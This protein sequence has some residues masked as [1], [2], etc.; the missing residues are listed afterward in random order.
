MSIIKRSFPPPTAHNVIPHQPLP[1]EHHRPRFGIQDR[2]TADAALSAD[3]EME[4]GRVSAV[5]DL[6]LE[7]YH[8]QYPGAPSRRGVSDLQSWS[9][10][11]LVR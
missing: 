2:L 7:D 10:G 5:A 1:V 9:V 4:L 8:A 11:D 6:A 3:V